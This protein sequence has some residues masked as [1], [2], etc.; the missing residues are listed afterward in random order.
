M[1]AIQSY[2]T[3]GASNARVDYL[4]SPSQST[5]IAK[6]MAGLAEIGMTGIKPEQLPR[7]LPADSMQ[8]ALVIMAEVRAFFQ[9][10]RVYNNFFFFFFTHE[11][12]QLLI[13]VS[14]TIYLSPSM[15]NL[16]GE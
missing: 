14:P 3:S 4:S 1:G 7:L 11:E 8:P 10:N 9:G 2:K 13:N 12:I 5:G 6:I 16:S 15:S